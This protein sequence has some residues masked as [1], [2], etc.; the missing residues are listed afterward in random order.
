[1]RAVVQRV[2]RGR[3]VVAGE[4]VGA[5]ERGLVAFVGIYS[6]DTPSDRAFIVDK[7]VHLRVFEDE[8][9]KM[10]LDVQQIGGGILA[11]PNFTVAGSA[12][13][14]R[15]PSF[16]AAMRPESARGMFDAL[17]E[18]LRALLPGRIATGRFG[19]DM[20]VELVNDGPVTLVLDSREGQ[21]DQS[22]SDQNRPDQNQSS[23]G[24]A[25]G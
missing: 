20:A 22:Q 13:R 11:V 21:P 7:L 8:Q 14:G 18:G 12:R 3:V 25:H 10:N 17:C 6:D 19:A 5:I 16:D 4:V 1:M 9:Q 2:E 15:R 24:Q 23:K